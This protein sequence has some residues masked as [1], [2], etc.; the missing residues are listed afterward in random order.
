ML[1]D[2]YEEK[3]RNIEIPKNVILLIVIECICGALALIVVISVL[4]VTNSE[5][6]PDWLYANISESDR[7]LTS[8][9]TGLCPPATS[10]LVPVMTN[11]IF[12][13]VIWREI[14]PVR[15]NYLW[16]AFEE[17]YQFIRWSDRRLTFVF[18]VQLDVPS[19]TPHLDIPDWLFEA[20]SR[21]GFSY[22]DPLIGKGFSPN[23][24]HPVLID[25][26]DYFIREFAN[27]YAHANMSMIIQIGS[28]GHFGEWSCVPYPN[29]GEIPPHN[30]T[31]KY[32]EHYV[33][34]FKGT[35][36][37][38]QLPR[39]LN[40]TDP[41]YGFYYNGFGDIFETDYFSRKVNG[42]YYLDDRGQVQLGNPNFWR[43]SPSSSSFPAL[44]SVEYFN[45]ENIEDTIKQAF[46]SHISFIGPN[47][48][49][50]IDDIHPYY[51]N[52]EKLIKIVGYRFYIK[53]MI[54]PN[55]ISIGE[56]LKIQLTIINKGSAPFYLKWPVEIF[57]SSP[58]T[59]FRS[60][61]TQ[62]NP[63]NWIGTTYV[64]LKE[65]IPKD[66]TSGSYDVCISILDPDTGK[67]GVEFANEGKARDG[68][69]C[70]GTIEI[71]PQKSLDIFDILLIAIVI[72][73]ATILM[74][75]IT[76]LGWRVPAGC[77]KSEEEIQD[78]K[79]A[80]AASLSKPTVETAGDSAPAESVMPVK[81]KEKNAKKE[82]WKKNVVNI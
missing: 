59:D 80:T 81:K 4:S 79:G 55:K 73:G 67:P 58:T 76:Y 82:G 45:D 61:R 42:T 5:T 64:T 18:R 10:L 78:S 9:L 53:E 23:Y 44:N 66:M 71:T 27:K 38:I 20:I 70:M 52:L 19:Y 14:E 11:M 35:K 37:T 33:R 56:T 65:K 24:A 13:P 47:Y 32:Y 57:L 68:H 22:D 40:G 63:I 62:E 6:K 26:H 3:S 39:P 29:T 48:P 51:K 74:V 77:A 12:V 69:Y 15:G 17:K 2:K 41:K 28:I 49:A 60:I 54:Y 36:A 16:D 7:I 34:Y 50:E 21:D 8:P 1:D 75:T 25:E 30:I 31:M 72:I 43:S 46:S